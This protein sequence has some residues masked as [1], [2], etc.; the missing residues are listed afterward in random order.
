MLITTKLSKRFNEIFFYFC[1]MRQFNISQK[2]CLQV[3]YNSKDLKPV[4]LL[5]LPSFIF[6]FPKTPFSLSFHLQF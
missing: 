3:L 1:K 4:S 6:L 2:S 5:S